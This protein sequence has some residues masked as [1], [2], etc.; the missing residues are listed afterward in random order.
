MFTGAILLAYELAEIWG[1]QLFRPAELMEYACLRSPALQISEMQ[2]YYLRTPPSLMHTVF[3]LSKP[4]NDRQH[5]SSPK[6]SLQP[7]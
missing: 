4:L 5:M 1:K 6:A 2:E 3:H 7:V